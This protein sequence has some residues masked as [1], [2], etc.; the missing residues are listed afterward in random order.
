MSQPYVIGDV[1]ARSILLYT[2]QSGYLLLSIQCECDHD[3]ASEC[4][5]TGHSAGCHGPDSLGRV[6]DLTAFGPGLTPAARGRRVAVTQVHQSPGLQSPVVASVGGN[7]IVFSFTY[8][9]VGQAQDR[10]CL[11]IK[12]KNC[13]HPGLS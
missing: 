11:T 1:T 7:G 3:P 12:K 13:S 6:P 5:S 4:R 2:P 10:A 8:R 9:V